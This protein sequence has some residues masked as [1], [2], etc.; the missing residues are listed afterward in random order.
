MTAPPN[1]RHVIAQQLLALCLQEHRVGAA[2]WPEWLSGLELGAADELDRITG[3]LR[4]TAHLDS[5]G[6]MLF[7]GPGA[8]RRYGRRH[9]L[10]LLSVLT[11][12]PQFTVLHGRDEVGAVDPL[13]FTCRTHGPRIIS[14]CGRSWKVTY[15]DWKRRRAFVEPS[16]QVGSSRWS[17]TPQPLS[18][19]MTNAMR[20]VVL[21]GQLP[22]DGL[23]RRATER[24]AVVRDE[25]APTVSAMGRVLAAWDSGQVR[26]W[27]WAGA[28]ANGVVGAAL[29][30]VDPGLV[31]DLNR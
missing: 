15:I 10:G 13:V 16:E 21:D 28:R 7:V 31:D 3:W 14:L 20:E 17:G 8:E 29:T 12:D 19:A 1:P 11:A 2:T 27:T 6:G 9:F 26:R 4:E 22:G 5:D 18:Y 30:A 24:L 23:S 25:L